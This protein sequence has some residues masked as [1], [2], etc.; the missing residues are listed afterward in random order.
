MPSGGGARPNWFLVLAGIQAGV[1][2]ALI[3]LGYVALD[4]AWHRRSVWTVP[5]LLASTFYGEAA[6]RPGLGARTGAGVALLVVLYGVLGAVFAL[7][8]RD[9]A[10]RLRV[11]LLGL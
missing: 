10:S 4:S 7:V 11:T 3:L 6:Y 1:I 2:G 9:Q 5:N 8:I